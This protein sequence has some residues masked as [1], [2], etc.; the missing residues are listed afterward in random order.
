MSNEELCLLIQAGQ[1]NLTGEL[2]E[3]VKRL[4]TKLVARYLPRDGSSRIDMDDLLQ[5]GFLG[6]L[7][8]VEAYNPGSGF[9]FATFL[10]Y[11]V[12][13]ACRDAMGIRSEKQ[14]KD[15][16]HK[17]LSL[18][19]PVS[20]DGE[21]DLTLGDSVQDSSLKYQY[22]D[23]IEEVDQAEDV[24][25]IFSEVNQLD[26]LD[27]KIFTAKFFDGH[28]ETDIASRHGLRQ[29]QVRNILTR[30]LGKIRHTRTVRLM[31]AEYRLD[32]MTNFHKT[33]GLQG[34]KTSFSSTV[35]DLTLK[36]Q[37]LRQRMIQ[38]NWRGV[39]PLE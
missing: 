26:P 18:S 24:R 23:L 25:R 4:V 22:D 8:A 17:A 1:S 3:Q 6:M 7:Q 32:Q 27:Q 39:A 14:S 21:T 36:R 34:F 5:A 29:Q 33:K 19:Q 28:M 13:T 20:A 31:S 30:S 15:P 35:E 11:N 10:N 37:E 9:Q 16:A 38:A 2:W 12:Q